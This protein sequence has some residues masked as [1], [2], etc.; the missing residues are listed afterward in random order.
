MNTIERRVLD[1]IDIPAMLHFLDQIVAI[2]SLDG[3]PEEYAVQERVAA[4][5]GAIGMDVDQW[6]IDVAELQQHPAFCWEVERSRGLGVV[7][8]W[9]AGIGPSLILNGH[10]DVVPAGD[11]S[12]WQYDPWRATL[13]NGNLY[14]RGVPIAATC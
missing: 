7:G 5:L 12:R 8:S 4:E 10:T 3:S 13:A 2:P 9:G 6:L 14:G 11:L 1:A